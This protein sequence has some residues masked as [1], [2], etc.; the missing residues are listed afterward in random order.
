LPHFHAVYAWCRWADDL[1]DETECGDRAL[2]LLDWWRNELIDGVSVHPVLIALRETIQ[3][4]RIPQEL[5][6]K[7]IDA[8][9]QDQ[10]IKRYDSFVQLVEYCQ[11]SADPVGRIVLH[12]F[13]CPTE[14][15]ARLSDDICTGLQ[16]ANFWQDVARDWNMKRIYVP[17]EDRI[18][19]RVA[20]AD[21]E[22]RKC[23]PEFRELLRFQV[24]RTRLFFERGASLIPLLPRSL[25]A[26]VDLFRLGGEA[27]LNAIERQNY[28]VWTIR[29][30]VGKRE[31]AG[32]LCRA[33]IRRLWC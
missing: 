1:A 29:P 30:T 8:F 9:E 23:T 31:K 28:D 25:R 16:L 15:N 14:R 6:L 3:R 7:L 33:L 20:D 4:F 32:L 12:L 22:G 21:F 18:R 2:A 17:N 10:R 26:Q 5:F 13:E 11:R 19:F 27:I 24:G